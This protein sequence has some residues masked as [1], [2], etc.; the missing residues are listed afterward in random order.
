MRAPGKINVFFEVGDV[1]DDGYH[2]VATA[3]QA[4]SVYEDVLAEHAEDFSD[5]GDRIRRRVRCPGG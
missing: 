2:D 1:Q 5:R 4:V 3:Y